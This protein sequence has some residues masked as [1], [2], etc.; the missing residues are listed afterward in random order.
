VEKG[1]TVQGHRVVRA[2]FDRL[3]MNGLGR[4]YQPKPRSS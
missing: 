1:E 2:S 4:V 3:S